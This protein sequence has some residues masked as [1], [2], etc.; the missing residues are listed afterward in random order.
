MSRLRSPGASVA[1]PPSPCVSICTLDAAGTL[2]TGCFRTLD[3][4]ALW[5]NL[6]PDEKRAVL[7]QLP[8]RRAH[9]SIAGAR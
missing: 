1:D 3:E 5:G 2:C 7:A 6:E 9:S 8:A 4:I